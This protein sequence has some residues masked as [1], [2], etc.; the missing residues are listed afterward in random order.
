MKLIWNIR[1]RLT[2][3][4]VIVLAAI[5]AGYV[6]AVFIFQYALLQRQM[7]RD[8]IQDVETVEGLL[9]FSGQGQLELQQ[10]YFSSPS[11]HLLL[12]RLMEVRD[13]SGAVLYRS[14]TLAGQAMGGAL[15]AGEGNESFNERMVKL[16]DRT[17]VLMISH[18]HPV[19]G[20]P[21]LIRL[22]YSLSPLTSRMTQ[23]LL[24]LLIGMPVALIAAGFGGYR[25][26]K[27]AFRPLQTM[28]ARAEQITAS[29][30]SQRLAVENE[31]DELGH[32]ARVVNH[33]LERLEQA[34]GQLQHFTA[35]AAHELRTPLASLRATGELAIE[36]GPAEAGYRDA[37]SS[38]LEEAVRLSQTIDGLL[39]LSKTEAQPTGDSKSVFLLSDVIA[40]ILNLLEV[41]VEERELTVTE[42]H[43]GSPQRGVL[44]DR[45]FVRLALLNVLH[46][47]TKFSPA[48]STLRII[49]GHDASH[50]MERVCIEDAGPGIEPGEEER[51]FDRFFT[52]RRPGTVAKS[53]S[54]LGLSIAK[55]TIER[56]GGRIYFD[57]SAPKG[58]RCCISLP[59]AR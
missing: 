58:A 32:M 27:H 16:P 40:E 33:M 4:Y 35:D 28:A 52:S 23:F 48:G 34:F 37:I 1:T 49:Y 9:Y 51:L 12:H 41:V 26:A 47:A 6:A 20:R 55:L 46:N 18:V 56:S 31:H 53:G 50:T 2:A 11:S 45:S 25:I 17:S 19:S 59:S 29:N 36:R 10:N 42:Q 13:L 21:V 44:A 57:P 43:E 39:L 22:G 5:L 54:G 38:M 15:S 7:Y 24:L 8:E 3:W 14:P 30:L